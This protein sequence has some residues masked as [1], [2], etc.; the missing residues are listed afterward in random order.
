MKNGKNTVGQFTAGN[1]GRPKGSRNKATIAT[2]SLLQG[3][4]EALTQTAVTKK[5]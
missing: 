4:A 2:E 3:L 5:H 1:S